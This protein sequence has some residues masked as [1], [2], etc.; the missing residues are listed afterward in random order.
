MRTHQ[1]TYNLLAATYIVNKINP[2]VS[3]HDGITKIHF[4]HIERIV[5]AANK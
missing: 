3:E 4:I 5:R 1:H 2:I